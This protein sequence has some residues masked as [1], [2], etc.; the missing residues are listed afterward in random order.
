VVVLA[1]ASPPVRFLI[2]AQAQEMIE[3]LEADSAGMLYKCHIRREAFTPSRPTL[4]Q[5]QRNYHFSFR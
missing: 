5:K 2:T 1:V 4:N 3:A